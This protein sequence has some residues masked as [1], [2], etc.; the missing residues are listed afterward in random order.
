[1]LKIDETI[2]II[3]VSPSIREDFCFFLG[4]QNWI[5]KDWDGYVREFESKGLVLLESTNPLV[6]RVL[7]KSFD[8][9]EPKIYYFFG[10]DDLLYKVELFGH[11]VY[12]R[13]KEWTT[14][15]NTYKK[16]ANADLF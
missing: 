2:G 14:F 13:R 6:E 5:E 12:N 3:I 11:Y 7:A 16:L 1:M 10:C 15:L 8:I 9:K 4:E